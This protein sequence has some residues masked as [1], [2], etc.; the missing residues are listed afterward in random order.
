MAAWG[1]KHHV[2]FMKG[3]QDTTIM[4]FIYGSEGQSTPGLSR[5]SRPTRN[6][7]LYGF[8]LCVE[9]LRRNDWHDFIHE[10]YRIR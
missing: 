6:F 8:V 10:R 1:R 9:Q 5:R 7:T 2:L 3:H 4:N